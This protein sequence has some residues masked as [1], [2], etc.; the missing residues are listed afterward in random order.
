[1]NCNFS[2]RHYE[3]IIAVA[4]QAA[5]QFS[6]FLEKPDTKKRIYMRHDVDISIRNAR[7]IAE[8]EKNNRVTS[9][10]FIQLNSPFYNIFADDNLRLIR[11]IAVLGHHIGIHFDMPVIPCQRELKL[12]EQICRQY[13]FLRGFIPLQKVV[14]FH[15]PSS[16]VPNNEVDCGDFVNAYSLQFRQKYISDSNGGWKEGCPCHILE[17]AGLKDVQILTHPFWW[18][19][20]ES[21]GFM[22]LY[23]RF[24]DSNEEKMRR[25]F[26]R[27]C[28][29][30]R[31]ILEG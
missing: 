25:D 16:R 10:F 30:F 28:R 8:I 23:Q 19:R 7:H 6:A 9:T 18:H 15:H 14:S 17:E 22:N 20:E 5:F 26:R 4:K 2:Y 13:V 21:G 11:E 1:M 27:T 29:V 31:E 24:L 12:E 3:E